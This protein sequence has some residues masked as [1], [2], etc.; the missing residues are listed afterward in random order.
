MEN[1]AIFASG[2]GTNCENIIRHFENNDKVRVTVVVSN[3]AD[4]FALVRARRLGV[5]TVVV[6]KSQ[7]A[8]ESEFV[9]LLSEYAVDYIVLA[10]FLLMVPPYLVKRYDRRIINIHPSLLP[11]YGGKGMYGRNVHEAVRAAN[12][13]ETG[14]T[15]HYVSNV[16]DGGD[17]IFQ[18]KTPV[19]LTATPEE[20]EDSVHLLEKK[21]FPDV[22]EKTIL[23]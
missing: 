11:K 10:G 19:A 21:Y 14:I 18:A 8:D 15:V 22:I 3:N 2:N 20:I 6:T 13:T 16:C 17:I 7:L 9:P 4:A 23:G 12:D 5:A 1:I